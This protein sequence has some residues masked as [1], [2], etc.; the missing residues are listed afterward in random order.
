MAYRDLF[1]SAGYYYARYRNHYPEELFVRLSEI[2]CLDAT[3]RL[4]DLGCG[5]GQL[6]LPL[7]SYFQEVVGLDTE[8]EM[9]AESKRI[10]AEKGISN[11]MWV[12]GRAEDIGPHMGAFRLATIGHA[13]HWMDRYAVLSALYEIIQPGGGVAIMDGCV[14][15]DANTSS[16]FRPVMKE[17]VRRYLGDKRRAGNGFYIPPEESYDVTIARTPFRIDQR[18]DIFF[19]RRWTVDDVVG[20]CFS[21][22]SSTPLILGDKKEAF[23]RD[24]RAELFKS[25]PSGEWTITQGVQAIILFRD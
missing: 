5:T 19:Q 25:N 8:P 11:I 10:A 17:V 23:E 9:L 14:P 1:K 7:A 4:L 24:L 6:I 13:F 3:G 21:K 18:E 15:P 22:S 16:D 2:Y 12:Q 20:N